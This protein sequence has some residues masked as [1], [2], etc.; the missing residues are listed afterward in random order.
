MRQSRNWP[1]ECGTRDLDILEA[2]IRP[3][4]ELQRFARDQ[5]GSKSGPGCGAE[6]LLDCATHGCEDDVTDNNHNQVVWNVTAAVV[7]DQIVARHC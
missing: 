5:D 6:M 3:G 2:M 1:S 7:R 4:A